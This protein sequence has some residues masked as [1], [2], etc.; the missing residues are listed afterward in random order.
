MIRACPWNMCS[1]TIRE[2]FLLFERA[3]GEPSVDDVCLK[4][5]RMRRMNSEWQDSET[6]HKTRV[7]I[8]MKGREDI[9]K[10]YRSKCFGGE[11]PRGGLVLLRILLQVQDLVDQCQ[12]RPTR[13]G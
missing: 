1:I 13:D 8:E 3:Q 9:N 10:V 2:S 12:R 11:R 7:L 4:S 6:R 5:I